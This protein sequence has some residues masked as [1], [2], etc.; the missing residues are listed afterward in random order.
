MLDFRAAPGKWLKGASRDTPLVQGEIFSSRWLYW[1]CT[2]QITRS[3]SW[4]K[5]IPGP[6]FIHGINRNCFIGM[7]FRWSLFGKKSFCVREK[8]ISRNDTTVSTRTPMVVGWL[9][10]LSNF[11]YISCKLI[12]IQHLT[13]IP[14]DF[15]SQKQTVEILWTDRTNGK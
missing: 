11:I 1:V 7:R 4:E 15:P 5:Q 3:P 2:D 8:W 9:A 12:L 14:W 10:L 6:S 13:V